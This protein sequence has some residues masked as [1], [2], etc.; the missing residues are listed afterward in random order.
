MIKVNN[1]AYILDKNETNKQHN[2]KN[3]Q[4]KSDQPK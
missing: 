2:V 4:Q 1:L 3:S